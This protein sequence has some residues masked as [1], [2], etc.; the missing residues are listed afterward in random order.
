MTYVYGKPQE[1]SA[2]MISLVKVD[3]SRLFKLKMTLPHQ[4]KLSASFV[5]RE[6]KIKLAL[7]KL[8]I[9]ICELLSKHHFPC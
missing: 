3:S 2:R 6:K 4:L 1:T 9:Y 5:Y 8:S 7:M